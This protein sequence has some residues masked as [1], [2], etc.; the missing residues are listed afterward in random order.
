[1]KLGFGARIGFVRMGLKLRFGA[2][3]IT[4]S[5]DIAQDGKAP[6]GF[7]EDRTLADYIGDLPDE[8]AEIFAAL[9]ERNG[10]DPR[11]M[12]AAHGL[13]SFANVWAKT[14]PSRNLVG[15]TGV[16]P[17]ALTDALGPSVRVGHRVRA[18]RTSEQGVEVAFDGPRGDGSLSARACILA[19]P[20]PLSRSLAPDLHEE[21]REALSLIRYGSFL[22]LGI[23]LEGEVTAPWRRAYAVATPGLGFSVLFNHDAMQPE[24]KQKGGAALM[25]FRGASGA[26]EEM[27][28]DDATLRARWCAD[29]ERHFPETRG[30]I[31]SIRIG[32]WPLGAPFGF[33][34]RARLK[35]ALDVRDPPLALAGDYLDFPN[36]EAAAESGLRAADRVREWLGMGRTG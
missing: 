27:A 26:R 2:R 10:A 6:S 13:R 23:A 24:G 25:L 29:L 33:P 8:V 32:R 15:G 28:L 36:M 20:A 31:A 21:T 19:T 4:G 1:M 9:T 34:G 18:V 7:G 30:R 12:S 11:E 5:T 3:R 17:A 22:S 35:D 14:A 16:L